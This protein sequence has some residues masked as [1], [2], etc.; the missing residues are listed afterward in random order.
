MTNTRILIVD[1][2]RLIRAS[3]RALLKAIPGLEI[4]GEAMMAARLRRWSL[5]IIQTSC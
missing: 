2:H 5:S 3:L 4:I 1:D